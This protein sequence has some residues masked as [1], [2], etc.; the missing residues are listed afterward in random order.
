MGDLN[1][2]SLAALMD[3]KL[4]KPN[5]LLKEIDLSH[6]TLRFHLNYLVEEALMRR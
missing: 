2:D 4:R 3:G 5:H 1:E 6:N